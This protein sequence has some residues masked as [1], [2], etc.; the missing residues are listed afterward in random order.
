MR[1]EEKED[2]MLED[3]RK[4]NDNNNKSILLVTDNIRGY[5]QQFNNYN[6]NNY[7]IIF[8][9]W[10]DVLTF[11]TNRDSDT[12]RKNLELIVLDISIAVEEDEMINQISAIT[13][14]TVEELK[15]FYDKRIFFYFTISI[16]EREIIILGISKQEDIRIQPF[17]VFDLIDLISTTKKKEMLDLIQLHDHSMNAYSSTDDKIKDA[18]KFLKK[19]IENNETTLL[20]LSRDIDLFDFKSQMAL[21][22]L[23]INKLEDDGSLKITYSKDW[24][25]FLIKK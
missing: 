7:K 23:D 4:N 5:Q 6:I 14:T 24:Y 21:S 18:I 17:S 10:N 13:I 15:I 25:L 11:F 1:K 16:Y 12:K 19:G 9:N 22:D 3:I 20:L 8:V 2:K